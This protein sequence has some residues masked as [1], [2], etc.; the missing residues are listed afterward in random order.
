MPD[1]CYYHLWHGTPNTGNRKGHDPDGPDGM[2][3]GPLGPFVIQ[4]LKHGWVTKVRSGHEKARIRQR[5]RRISADPLKFPGISSN[6]LFLMLKLISSV[7]AT[8]MC[9]L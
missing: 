7:V 1:S 9:H 5:G 4:E 3:H 2:A 6:A 8:V